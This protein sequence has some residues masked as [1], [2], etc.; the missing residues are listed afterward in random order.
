MIKTKEISSL[1]LLP[2]VDNVENRL[3]QEREAPC[4][5]CV[6]SQAKKV[7]SHSY[8]GYNSVL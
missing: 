1:M 2:F 5:D 8:R 6:K 4:L 3:E 7:D